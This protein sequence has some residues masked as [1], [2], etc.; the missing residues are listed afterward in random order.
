MYMHIHR[1]FLPQ[2]PD[3]SAMQGREETLINWH[4]LI[5]DP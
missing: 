5:R 2:A 1:L 4:Q 3:A